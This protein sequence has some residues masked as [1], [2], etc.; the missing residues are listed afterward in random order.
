MLAG[1]TEE[2][3]QDTWREIEAALGGFET[4]DGFSGPC[5]LLVGVGTN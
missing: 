1:L 2:D 3:R 4:E 5:E